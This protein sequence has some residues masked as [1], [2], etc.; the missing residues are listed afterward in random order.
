MLGSVLRGVATRLS[1][2]AATGSAV[3]AAACKGSYVVTSPLWS[4]PQQIRGFASNASPQAFAVGGRYVL[5]AF[6]AAAAGIWASEDVY[7]HLYLVPKR[8]FLDIFTASA[9][10]IGWCRIK[11]HATAA[12]HLLSF[13][14]SQ[15]VVPPVMPLPR[16]QAILEARP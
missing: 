8:L 16:L 4:S 15:H 5:A 10:V 13:E 3:T 14:L 12:A 6:G 2:A 9:I 11:A 1:T 7:T